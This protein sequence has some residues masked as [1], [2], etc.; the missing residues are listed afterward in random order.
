[1]NSELDCLDKLTVVVPT[2]KNAERLERTLAFISRCHFPHV[3]VLDGCRDEEF[4][5][6]MSRA[7]PRITYIQNDNGFLERLEMAAGLVST[8]YVLMWADDEFWLPSFAKSAVNFLE[9]NAAFVQCVGVALSFVTTPRPRIGVAYPRLRE[10]A[11]L[12]QTPAERIESRLLNWSWGGF[13]GVARTSQ[14]KNSI[15]IIVEGQFGARWSSEI[16]YE[17]SLAWQGGVQVLRELAWFRSIE[18]ESI[19]DSPDP[20][21]GSQNPLFQDWWKT[22]SDDLR[23]DF[24]NHFGR[25]LA[26]S[27]T[28]IE[29]WTKLL[30]AYCRLPYYDS[31]S[32]KEGNPK[33]PVLAKTIWRR[34]FVRLSQIRS[35]RL[36]RDLRVN[37]ALR[38]RLVEKRTGIDVSSMASEDVQLVL[39]SI[40]EFSRRYKEKTSNSM[41]FQ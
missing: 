8:E 1:M 33:V 11:S 9:S 28:D 34:T 7:H 14:W 13:W 22:I 35:L 17:A 40:V 5:N 18:R 37:K 26:L 4:S 24:V 27:A 31:A 32:V 38:N 15:A 12:G 25:H 21:L 39:D 30:D 2:Y 41:Q 6:F 19:V 20:T 3:I 10:L 23:A 36:S 29:T 16:Q